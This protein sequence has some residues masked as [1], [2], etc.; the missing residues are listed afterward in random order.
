V[1]AVEWMSTEKA[2]EHLDF[3]S[4]KAFRK[5]L[6]RHPDK[7]RRYYLGRMLRFRRVDLDACLETTPGAEEQPAPLKLVG[8]RR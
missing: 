3:P 6:A 7:P 1:K 8:G 5:W 4:A 2:A